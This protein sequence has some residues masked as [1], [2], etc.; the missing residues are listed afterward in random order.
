M[1]ILF[2]RKLN[3]DSTRVWSLV[4]PSPDSRWSTHY[5][6]IPNS[7]EQGRKSIL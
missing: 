7:N 5:N 4:P 6:Q 1:G 2:F 3:Q